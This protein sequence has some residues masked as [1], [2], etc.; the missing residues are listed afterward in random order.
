MVRTIRDD[1]FAPKL[2]GPHHLSYAPRMYVQGRFVCPATYT[3]LIQCAVLALSPPLLPPRL[4]TL[5]LVPCH[6]AS[7]AVGPHLGYRREPFSITSPET[8]I[9][10]QRVKSPFLRLHG[11]PTR[12]TSPE[13][14]RAGGLIPP[15][16]QN[17]RPLSSESFFRPNKFDGPTARPR[18][19]EFSHEYRVVSWGGGVAVEQGA[20]S[21]SALQHSL[22]RVSRAR[23]PALR[24]W[25]SLILSG[26]GPHL[27]PLLFWL[28]AFLPGCLPANLPTH[29]PADLPADLPVDLLARLAS[30]SVPGGVAR[31]GRPGSLPQAGHQ[32]G[33][34][35]RPA[36]LAAARGPPRAQGQHLAA[37]GEGHAPQRHLPQ[38]IW[39][40]HGRILRE[41]S[42]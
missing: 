14:V 4:S 41:L 36:G 15:P 3:I 1:P 25:L 13:R 8:K 7:L 9:S 26:S 40:G 32:A 35:G 6:F 5:N 18:R 42:A 23:P 2:A 12:N 28:P 39:P 37:A 16:A 31:R 21:R 33:H 10:R 34:G 27:P 30:A 22:W 38:A 19:M 11:S 24:Q 17:S 20:C 29:L